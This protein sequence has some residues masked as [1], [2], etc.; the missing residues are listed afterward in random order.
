MLLVTGASGF[1]GANLAL[2]AA[3]KGRDVVAATNRGRF[4]AAGVRTVRADLTVPGAAGE[5][6]GGLKPEWVVNCA[7]LA[8]VDQCEREP[9]YARRLNVELPHALALACA[10]AGVRLMQISTDSV[11]DGCLGGY[12]ES[13]D[14]GPLNVY[15]RTKL[16]G[17]CAVLRELPDALVLRTNFIGLSPLG[18]VGLADWIVTR[19]S[20]GNQITGFWDVVFSPLLANDLATIML[21]MMDRGLS[22]L[23]H[24]A[25]SDCCS[26][27][28]FALQLCTALGLSADLVVKGSSGGARLGAARPLNTSLSSSRA[29]IALGRQMPKVS[30]AIEGYRALR[31]DGY[32]A[33]LRATV[34]S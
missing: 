21:A 5:I 33:R 19:A 11:F 30:D 28:Q 12:A 31:D 7:A 26:K 3:E 18:D 8:N 34:E 1:L 4:S 24:V 16:E 22:G 6:I 23:H 13:D 17:E 29:E 27:Y 14:P 2:T 25:A 10:E 20:S 32:A 15:A 9:E